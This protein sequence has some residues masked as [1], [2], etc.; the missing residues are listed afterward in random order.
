MLSSALA[1]EPSTRSPKSA[2]F[3]VII[4]G[5]TVYDGTGAQPRHVDLAI[6]G[7]RI[8]GVGDFKT[9]KA[10]TII[11]ATDLAVAPG[12]I[13]MLSWSNESLIQDGR[14]Q[15]E[16]RQGVT[17][18]I[19]GEGESMGPVNDRVREHM[20]REQSDI[21]YEIKW[22]TLAEYLHYL[23]TRGISCNV[24][25]FIGAATLREYV[26]GFEDKAPTRQQ[27]D[28]MRELV[29]KEMEAG[30][31]GIGTALMYPPAFFAKTE[32]LTE[33]CKVAAKYQGKYISHI[34]SEGNRLLESLDEL[35]RISREAGI[36][37][38]LYHIK[39]AGQQNW[40]KMDQLLS[41]I[42]VAQKEGLKIRANMYMYTAS[43]TGLDACLPPWTE[44]GGYPALF[45][46]LRDPATREKIAAQVKTPTDEWEN[47]YIAAGGPDRILLVGFKSEK[48]KPLTGKTLA[49]VAEMR[50]KDPISTIMD[51][52]SEDE[53]RIG[54][55]YFEMSEEN[56]KKELAKP[57]ISFGS[58][59]ASQA[60]EGVFLKSNPHPRAYG[61]FAR[62]LGKYVRDE[63]VIPMT[64]A[65]RRLSGL[66]ATNLSLDHRGF[67]K[68][69]MFADVV[70]FDPATIADRATFEKPHQYA[71]GVKHVFVNGVQ[72]LRDGEHT[73]AK[74]GRALW[75]PGKKL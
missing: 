48:L 13:N 66:P 41:H 29:R 70:L 23:E 55:I 4:K 26:I 58:D 56:I 43:G 15:S 51:L 36:P 28:Q 64:E 17:T 5:G 47:V 34:R 24:A 10:K 21:K 6:R 16:I 62:V 9:A 25:S 18:E 22:N 53:S 61:N 40:S 63:K 44:D 2:G 52:I 54:T 49:A 7:D 65:I 68:E 69:G 60:P 73:G 30:A 57:W 74:P 20:L 14:S 11:D 59:E 19:M 42:E 37:A 38:E 39:A 1:T 50:G 32:E 71:V 46:R 33:L 45:K 31:L 75:G 72:V 3:D 67:I 35:I 12:F 8:A 27:L